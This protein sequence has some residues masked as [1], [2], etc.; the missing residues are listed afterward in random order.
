MKPSREVIFF[1]LVCSFVLAIKF[2]P[3]E[4]LL[5][6]TPERGI[7]S[8]WTSQWLSKR[9]ASFGRPDAALKFQSIASTAFDRSLGPNESDSVAALDRL[10]L[11]YKN[12]ED[13]QRCEELQIQVL[14]RLEIK[15]GIQDL[16][17]L[18]YL[19]KIASPWFKD[20]CTS[21][22]RA[23][24]LQEKLVATLEVSQVGGTTSLI[25]AMNNLAELNGAVKDY[26]KSVEVRKKIIDLL[27]ASSNSQSHMAFILEEMAE[28]FRH[29]GQL[30]ERVDALQRALETREKNKFDISN[31]DLFFDTDEV[32]KYGRLSFS[33]V[34]KIDEWNSKDHATE[35]ERL[36]DALSEAGRE[37]ESLNL[38]LRA[39][40]M[41]EV[42]RKS[43][44]DTYLAESA[45]SLR[46]LSKTYRAL[47]RTQEAQGSLSL[48]MDLSDKAYIFAAD[49]LMTNGESIEFGNSLQALILQGSMPD[50]LLQIRG[51]K[52]RVQ[53][54]FEDAWFLQSDAQM[55]FQLGQFGKALANQERAVKLLATHA[56]FSGARYVNARF[57]LAQFHMALGQYE[58]ASEMLAWV[59]RE[60]VRAYG[61]LDEDTLT[62]MVALANLY[63]DT[64]DFEKALLLRK[65][66]VEITTTLFGSDSPIRAIAQMN[67]A[68]T[69]RDLGQTEQSKEVVASAAS[70]LA[71]KTDLDSDKAALA[72]D[73]LAE[74]ASQTLKHEKALEYWKRALEIRKKSSINM[75]ARGVSLSRVASGLASMGNLDEAF[76]YQREALATTVESVGEFHLATAR[77]LEKLARLHDQARQYETALG[78]GQRALAI[79][80]V[81]LGHG[82]AETA[83]ALSLSAQR[84]Q[85]MGE[86]DAA[87]LL[88]KRAVNDYQSLR[89]RVSRIG[90]SYLEAYTKAVA[91]PYHALASELL[92]RGRFSEAQVVLEMLKQEEHFDFI[93]RSQDADPRRLNLPYTRIEQS[94]IDRYEKVSE[95]VISLGAERIQIK[96]SVQLKKDTDAQKKRLREIDADLKVANVAFDSF[97]K[98]LRTA[99]AA[100]GISKAF[101]YAETSSDKTKELLGTVKK[102]G[103]DVVLVQ[104]FIASDHLGLILTTPEVQVVR[105]FNISERDLNRK[106]GE[107]R[108]QLRDKASDPLPLANALYDIL[109]RPI[110][111][112]LQ[113][114]GAR[115]VMVS[116]DGTLRYVPFGALHDGKQYVTAKWNIPIYTSVTQGQMTQTPARQWRVVG[117]G[118]TKSWA[119]FSALPSV[120]TE[121]TNIV[122]DGRGG[123]ILPGE[124]YLDEAFSASRLKDAGLGSSELIHIASHFRFSPG[125][126]AN[127]YLLLGDGQHLTLRDIRTQ[128]YRFENADLLT[129][130]AC[131]TALGG[132]RDG[133]GN[134]IEGFGVIAQQQGAKA[135]LATLWPVADRS[136]AELMTEMYRRRQALGISKIEA[137]RQAQQTLMQN[138]KYAHPFYWAP[139]VLM[140]NW[141]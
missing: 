65:R 49:S 127:S 63:S 83:M 32:N 81:L 2:G 76:K 131:E 22:I 42:L 72:F 3:A 19:S 106:V 107:F 36:A 93:R 8:A 47:K 86:H 59:L 116:L 117:L 71:N 130:S 124:K 35:I 105:K 126:E 10:A 26:G 98:E 121:I 122:K 113:Q 7:I 15:P 60:K 39:K 45:T 119:D 38:R 100:Q 137:L 41:W 13:Y 89:E 103:D 80:D 30:N 139:F 74:E 18:R 95:R 129:L 16:Q 5:A 109:L 58:D 55:D 114:S 4:M 75:L 23:L 27:S 56:D 68:R 11:L 140:G 28:S 87:I 128:K 138:P 79:F 12:T 135:V 69:Y 21:D 134:E 48:A 120:K 99:F 102:L 136:T 85:E 96:K 53:K 108:R 133:N 50:F 9:Y 34:Y 43:P 57:A 66:I 14:Q 84:L 111:N 46:K 88:G 141:K 67:L 24:D 90:Q 51:S 77:Q 61:D 70:V 6:L 44:T 73:L 94:W 125:T 20:S 17:T 104:Y 101:Q 118:V 132:G 29:L 78:V 62:A 33:S 25:N 112:D 64:S 123:G 1:F 31:S 40:D 110:E 97:M 52:K 91:K 37:I 54:F 82:S 115:T 92:D